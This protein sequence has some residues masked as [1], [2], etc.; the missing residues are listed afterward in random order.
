MTPILIGK[1]KNLANFLVKNKSR[2]K[3][4]NS[5]FIA[6]IVI[7]LNI[8]NFGLEKREKIM[9]ILERES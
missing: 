7:R 4:F 3:I 8:L 6:K 9:R 5:D 2:L 1:I